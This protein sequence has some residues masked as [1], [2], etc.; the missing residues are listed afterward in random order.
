MKG[1]TWV[2]VG[3][4][5]GLLPVV[6]C[7]VSFGR[8]DPDAGICDDDDLTPFDGG[9]ADAGVDASMD[10]SV[11]NDGGM[12]ASVDTT[13]GGLTVAQFCRA[14][15]ATA[16]K[17]RDLF[18]SV[19]CGCERSGSEGDKITRFLSASLAYGGED[20]E[21]TCISV[22]NASI[23]AGRIVYAPQYAEACASKFAGQFALPEVPTTCPVDLAAFEAQLAHGAQQLAQIPECRSAFA[24]KVARDGACTQLSKAGA[25]ESLECQAGLRCLPVLGAVDDAGVTMTTCQPARALGETCVRAVQCAD[26]LICAGLTGQSTCIPSDE[27]RLNNAPCSTSIE[28]IKGL[29]CSG[30]SCVPATAD[31][32]CTP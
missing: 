14:Q 7:D 10:A 8:C 25:G 4:L 28:C 21:G 20:P 23:S 30:G 26:G 22:R 17:W 2:R 1:V 15:L 12:D 5:V 18:D 32:V 9:N 6:G 3:I 31:S 19:G 13:D 29:V 27:L 11:P 16:V 24:G